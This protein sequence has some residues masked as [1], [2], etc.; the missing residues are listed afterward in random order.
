VVASGR[1]RLAQSSPDGN[2]LLLGSEDETRAIAR[3]AARS[4]NSIRSMSPRTCSSPTSRQ[5]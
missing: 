2:H 5:P 3:P 1:A 4:S